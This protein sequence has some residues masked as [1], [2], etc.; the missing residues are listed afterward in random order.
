MTLFKDDKAL[1]PAYVQYYRELG[2]EHFYLYFNGGVVPSDVPQYDDVTYLSWDHPYHVHLPGAYTPV[3][4][5]L[6][7]INDM[8]YYGKFISEY[9]LYN[10]MDEFIYWNNTSSLKSFVIN[11]TK[12]CYAFLNQFVCLVDRNVQVKPDVSNID[13]VNAR[14]FEKLTQVH[15]FP[16]RSK[17]IVK[18]AAVQFMCV[19]E[20]KNPTFE[21]IQNDILVF[22]SA[23]AGHY[24]VCNFEGRTRFG[25]I[26]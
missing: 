5:Q 4:A 3:F 16:Y 2:V 7:A 26:D 23:D 13:L 1:I 17:C 19:H 24:H 25:I 10:D 9:I 6:G 14:C 18:P 21:E 22:D 15:A 12:T 8:L 20:I 11:N